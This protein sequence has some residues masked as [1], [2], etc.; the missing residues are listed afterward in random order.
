MTAKQLLRRWLAQNDFQRALKGLD[1]LETQYKDELLRDYVTSEFGRL[2]NLERQ[3]AE[4][5]ISSEEDRLQT[6]KI[7]QAL[8]S[9]VNGLSD[10]WTAE[11]MEAIPSILPKISKITWKKY[12]TYLVAAITLLVV[13]AKF[14]GSGVEEL[15]ANPEAKEQPVNPAVPSQQVSTSGDNSP[16][17]ITNGGNSS[18]TYADDKPQKDSINNVQFSLTYLD[19]I[20]SMHKYLQNYEQGLTH[21]ESGLQKAEQLNQGIDQQIKKELTP[22]MLNNPEVK[23]KIAELK[24][25]ALIRRMKYHKVGCLNGLKRA[26]EAKELAKQLWQ[27]GTETKDTRLLEDLKKD[28]YDFGKD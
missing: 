15:F 5:T 12:A 16:G 22:E 11:G 24:N 9:T 6:A 19:S 4:E 23:A 14:S 20:G 10:D 13:M 8:I 1:H 17:V 7:R 2:N 25:F 28:G 18:I 3:R 21:L 26:K 27:E